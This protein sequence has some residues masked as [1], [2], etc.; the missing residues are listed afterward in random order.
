MGSC[1]SERF[2]PERYNQEDLS[3]YPYYSASGFLEKLE[4]RSQSSWEL[5]RITD[6]NESS[7]QENAIPLLLDSIVE[8]QKRLYK[9]RTESKPKSYFGEDV[10]FTTQ[11]RS[12]EQERKDFDILRCKTSRSFDD[13]MSITNHFSTPRVFYSDDPG[14]GSQLKSMSSPRHMFYSPA[15]TYTSSAPQTSSTYIPQSITEVI[16]GKLYLGCEEK[17]ADENELLSLG[18]TH[19]LC[20]SN[21]VIP[22]KGI[23]HKHIVMNDWGRTDLNTVLEKAYP[24]MERSQ[25]PGKKLFVHCKLGQNRSAALVISFLV[26]NKGL[27]VYE[28]HKM[29][30]EMRPVVQVHHNYAKMLL[31]LEKELFGETSLPEDWMEWNGYSMTGIPCYKS[32]TLTLTEQHQFKMNQKLNKAGGR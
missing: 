21:H 3:Y 23:E 9:A 12:A 2:K 11:R 6:F 27:T 17:A 18:I 25:K 29:L 31:S 20:V 26:K 32:E 10:S 7:R 14:L 24:F 4:E 13:E 1:Y 28:A 22:I 5:K 8:N 16:P 19:L 15:S 30:K